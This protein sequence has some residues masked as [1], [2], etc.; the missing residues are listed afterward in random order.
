MRKIYTLSASV[1]LLLNLVLLW[2]CGGGKGNISDARARF[3][4][5]EYS[6]AGE[7][8]RKVYSGSNKSK[9]IKMEACFYAA[10][11]YRLSNNWAQA[12]NWYSKTLKLDANHKLAK[13]Y[14]IESLLYAEKYVEAI[15]EIK[16]YEKIHGTDADVECLMKGATNAQTWKNAKTR[17]IVENVKSLNTQYSDFAPMWFRK[18]QMMFTSDRIETA[19]SGKKEYTWTGNGYSD[20]YLTT[21]KLNKKTKAIEGYSVPALVD[22]K[23]VNGKWNDGTVCFDS[24]GTTMYLTKCNYGP[25]M[26][27][28]GANCQ[29][30][31]CKLNG[32]EWG[33]AERLPFCSDSFNCGQPFLSRDGKTLYFSSDRPGSIPKKTSVADCRG[34]QSSK[35]LWM[36]SYSSRGNTWGD[37]V[38]LGTVI[39]TAGDEMYPYVHE[40]GTLYFA[41]D[42]H[43]GIGGLDIFYTKGS[44]TDW[45]DPINMKSP[46]NSGG[47]DFSMILARDKESGFFA[48]NRAGGKGTT[49]TDDIYRF[50][51]APLKFTLSGVVKN[52][53]TGAVIP[54]AK[55]YYTNSNDTGRKTIVTDAAGSYKI[56]LAS[57][58]DYELYASRLE[59]YYIDSKMK[60]VTTKGREQSEDLVE[61]FELC[62]LPLDEFI[63]VEGI[64]YDLDKADLRPRSREILDSLALTLKR[65]GKIRIELGSHTDCR[66]DSLYNINLSQRRA[67]SA[68]AR[69]IWNGID[70]ARIIARGYGENALAIPKCK[71]ELTDPGNK[72][73]S[74][75]EHQLNRRTTVKILDFNYTPPVAIP[76]TPAGKSNRPGGRRPNQR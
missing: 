63:N 72:I 67:D 60:F 73:C 46:V 23:N 4:K 9:E 34:E 51:M 43:C 21:F 35:D 24:K 5:M 27:G 48:S 61:N 54:G 8:Y 40:D 6:S 53:S 41:S 2:S 3:C 25:D 22:K 15:T 64:Y 42:G 13:L 57:N 49:G 70:S 14:Y 50:T 68:V 10:E 33:E 17:Y 56:T 66:A 37:P 59:D 71:C 74:E 7:I 20:V 16:D 29:I 52:C 11:C 55:I 76:S 36:V 32:T 69:L 31:V 58:T 28:K 45:S 39:N 75:E 65:Y 38:N 12:G 44:G 19:V 47:D 62:L 30:Y 1:L 18:D 26:N